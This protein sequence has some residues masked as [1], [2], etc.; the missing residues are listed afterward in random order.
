[1]LLVFAFWSNLIEQVPPIFTYFTLKYFFSDIE[2]G[3]KINIYLLIS[4]PAIFSCNNYIWK[5]ISLGVSK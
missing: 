3:G 5:I 2:A 1:M 4:F